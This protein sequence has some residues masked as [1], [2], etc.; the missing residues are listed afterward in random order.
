MSSLL[1]DDQLARVH[2]ER[3]GELADGGRP[4]LFALAGLDL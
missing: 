2:A 1:L 3:V 4:R